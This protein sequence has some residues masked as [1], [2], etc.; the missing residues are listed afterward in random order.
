MSNTART[1]ILFVTLLFLQVFL[2]RQISLGFGGKDYLFVFIL[3]L[4]IALLPLKTPAPLVVIGGFFIGLSTDFFYETLGLHAAAGSFAGY[5]RQFVLKYIEPRD[6]YKVKSST[7]GRLMGRNW[8][9]R[10]LF[11]LLLG[12]CLFY[13]SIEA[14]SHVFWQD[15]ILQTLF[16]VPVSFVLCGIFVLFFQPRL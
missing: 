14:F 9:M 5:I 13:F 3:P 8:W 10:Y 6:G 12:Y 7:Q 15:I 4:F 2:F 11:S 16:T 1:A